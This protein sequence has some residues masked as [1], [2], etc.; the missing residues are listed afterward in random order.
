M[1]RGIAQTTVSSF[2][3]RVSGF[4]SGLFSSNQEPETKNQEPFSALSHLVARVGA[5]HPQTAFAPHNLA[6]LT[7]AFDRRS[8]FHVQPCSFFSF[9][10]KK[11]RLS[12]GSGFK[13]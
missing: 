13:T 12:D 10:P 6:V 11:S 3:F 2:W 1:I 9:R 5:D 4:V 7:A 8:Y